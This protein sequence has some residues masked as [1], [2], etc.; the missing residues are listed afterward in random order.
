MGKRKEYNVQ[1]PR[2]KE[3]T[4]RFRDLVD[5]HGGVSKVSE[6]TKISRPTI[7]FWYNGERTP[8]AISLK[9]LSETFGISVDYLLGLS[10]VSS[11]DE[12]L[13][14]AAKTTGLSEDSITKIINCREY[15]NTL[16][17]VLKAPSFQKIIMNLSYMEF[18]VN[19][20]I[21]PLTNAKYKTEQEYR[22]HYTTMAQSHMLFMEKAMRS[23]T[24][25]LFDYS[26][27]IDRSASDMPPLEELRK[28]LNE[29]RIWKGEEDFAK[30]NKV[31]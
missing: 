20:L 28:I 11:R 13:Q 26:T 7:N 1:K 23:L 3:F 6:L 21:K 2:L 18:I 30:T 15:K 5:N 29:S 22:L 10:P 25:E 31:K 14:S 8:D 12:D 4:E 19:K 16:D 24:D 27:T 17:A 9:K